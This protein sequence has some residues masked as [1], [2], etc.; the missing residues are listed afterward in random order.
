MKNRQWIAVLLCVLLSSIFFYS[1][2]SSESNADIAKPDR[3]TSDD[4]SSESD[5]ENTDLTPTMKKLLEGNEKC[6]F[7][8]FIFDFLPADESD[9]T[10]PAWEVQSDEFKTFS[11][12]EKY[13][14]SV[15]CEKEAARLLYGED[16]EGSSLYGAINK[17]LYLDKNGKLYRNSEIINGMGTYDIDWHDYDI[18]IVSLSD[19]TCVFEMLTTCSNYDGNGTEVDYALTF[20]AILEDNE[21]KLQK[22][23]F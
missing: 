14:R 19:D 22:H 4:T 5:A 15:Y 17:P 20:T 13:V 1:C 18:K 12:L 8:I 6:V 3:D 21:W 23:V 7:D 9:L 2:G 10:Q 16:E 11:D